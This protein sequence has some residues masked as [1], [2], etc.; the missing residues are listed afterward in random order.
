[1]RITIYIP[2]QWSFL[3][4]D[5]QMFSIQDLF[6]ERDAIVAE[7]SARAADELRVID[8]RRAQLLAIVGGEPTP[9]K[10]PRI[11]G[12]PKYRNPK[13]PAQT[14]TGR[15]KTPVWIQGLKKEDCRIPAI[16]A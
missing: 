4:I 1:M 11:N 3:M 16:P 6:L 12:V 15:G 2:Q 10:K 14:W 13:D 7:I 5:Y 9:A 8:A